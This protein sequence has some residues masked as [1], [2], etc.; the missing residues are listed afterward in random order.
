MVKVVGVVGSP[1]KDGNTEFLLKEALSAAK[2]AGA[3]TEVILLHDKTIGPCDGCLSCHKTSKCRIEDDFQS[4]FEK[5]KE[6]DGI[7]LASPV[8]FGSVTPQMK[9]LIDRAGYINVVTPAPDRPLKNKVGCPI[10]VARKSGHFLTYAQMLIFFLTSSM[11]V[12]GGAIA[13]ALEKGD[14]VK[15]EEGIKMAR[16]I[17]KRIVWLTKKLQSP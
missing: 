8:Y 2:S 15:D 3:K 5:M 6:A 4:V 1:R 7:I 13:S 11:I 14:V 12:P 9:S 16:G 17:G 10:V